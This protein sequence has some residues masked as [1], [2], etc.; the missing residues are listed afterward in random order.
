MTSEMPAPATGQSPQ[1]DYFDTAS[2]GQ[3]LNLIIHLLHN[4]R[5]MPC[6]C[7]P[8]GLGKTRFARHLETLLRE[9]FKVLWTPL[10]T[11]EDLVPAVCRQLG[12]T[13]SPLPSDWTRVLDERPV[14]KPLLVLVDDAER[15]SPNAQQAM[16]DMV[17]AGVRFVLVG[18]GLPS[19]ALKSHVREID[20]PALNLEETHEFL[21]YLGRRAGVSVASMDAVKLHKLS[22]GLPGIIIEQMEGRRTGK[23]VAPKRGGSRAVLL[24]VLLVG[25]AG[26]AL[27]YQDEINRLFGVGPAH[28]RYTVE[29]PLPPQL[30][31]GPSS[32]ETA[33]AQM[34]ESPAS[35]ET[36]GPATAVMTAPAPLVTPEPKAAP[37]VALPAFRLDTTPQPEPEIAVGPEAPVAAPVPETPPAAGPVGPQAAGEPA[38]PTTAAE[39]PA[40]ATPPQPEPATTPAPP[41]T[42]TAAAGSGDAGQAWLRSQPGDHFTLQLVGAR[43][44]SAIDRFVR[45]HDLPEP[46]GVFVRDLG[47]RPWYSLVWGT[48]PSRDAALAAGKRLPARIQK[49][50]WPRDFASIQAQLGR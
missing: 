12:I 2:R 16:L 48:F 4:T 5:E 17:D 6:I 15:L 45:R 7:G 18:A 43:E 3:C 26:L 20:L 21:N 9:D 29:L 8:R 30:E 10:K 24:A 40:E 28:D 35:E 50:I 25:G 42:E 11:G 46:Y 27:W 36:A 49:D 37:E 13:Q 1:G 38:E 19:P 44:R 41:A 33:P 34:L 39:I 47:G 22:R 31:P 23:A 14:G 32:A